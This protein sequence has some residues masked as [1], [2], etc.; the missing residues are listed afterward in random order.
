MIIIGLL[1][2]TLPAF[3][4]PAYIWIAAYLFGIMI[5]AYSK[6]AA[7]EQL[8]ADVKGG[9]LERPARFAI[10]FIGIVA[11][12]FSMQYLVYILALLAVLANITA[13]QRIAKAGKT[14]RK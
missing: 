10:L 5:T 8:D 7:K 6:A 11:A 4:L 2:T 12:I 14:A 3:L 13:L 9:L 1:F